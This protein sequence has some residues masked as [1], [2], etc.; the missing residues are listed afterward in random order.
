MLVVEEILEQLAE[1]SRGL[2]TYPFE[3]EDVHRVRLNLLDV[4][5][6]PSVVNVFLRRFEVRSKHLALWFTKLAFGG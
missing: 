1:S 3:S 5:A 4:G 2:Q 6:K